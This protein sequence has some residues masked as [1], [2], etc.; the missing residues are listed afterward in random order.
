MFGYSTQNPSRRSSICSSMED[1]R[2]IYGNIGLSN[3][4][5]ERNI[6]GGS[7]LSLYPSR[8]GSMTDV[9]RISRNVTVRS[10]ITSISSLT[11][12]VMNSPDKSK[13]FSP[14]GTPLNSPTASRSASP[15]R[16]EDSEPGNLI[17]REFLNCC[18]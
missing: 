17:I 8:Y 9:N 15:E 18:F 2:L 7:S 4:I 6:H 1:L 12:S 11:P 5:Q 10:D 13:S 14:T 3:V 16:K